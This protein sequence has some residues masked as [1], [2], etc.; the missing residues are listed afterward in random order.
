VYFTGAI[1]PSKVKKSNRSPEEIKE[2]RRNNAALARQ[3]LAGKPNAR[4]GILEYTDEDIFCEGSKG[5]IKKYFLTKVKYQCTGCGIS[6]WQGEPIT[7]DMDHINGDN[8]DNRFENLR[9]LCPNCH[10]QTPTYKNKN[11][12]GKRK[13]SDEMIVSALLTTDNRRQAL[14]KVG[15]PAQ[16]THYKRLDKIIEK[17]NIKI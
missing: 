7:L 12:N 17:Y 6:D 11:G 9:L 14:I 2:I 8:T 4:K 15:L 1:N 5:P 3:A 16:G 13:V 10:S